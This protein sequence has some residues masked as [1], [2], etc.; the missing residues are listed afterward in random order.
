[1]ELLAEKLR[2]AISSGLLYNKIFKIHLSFWNVPELI[3]WVEGKT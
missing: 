2:N 1:M 3:E